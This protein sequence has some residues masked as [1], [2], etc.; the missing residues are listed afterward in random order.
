MKKTLLVT[1]VLSLLVI[2]TAFG[3]STRWN[4]MGGEHRFVIDTTNYSLYPGRITMFGNAAFIIPTPNF[5]DN[6]FVAGTLVNVKNM[7]LAYHYNLDTS[8]L[9]SLRGAL[10]GLKPAEG[11]LSDAQRDMSREDAGTDEWNKAKD[12]YTKLSQKDRLGSLVLREFPDL[13]WAMKTGKISLGARLALSMDSLSDSASPIEKAMSGG[14][15]T[16]PGEEASASAM[17]MDILLGATMYET[18][19]GDLD[20]GLGIGTQSYSDEDPNS[21]LTFESEGGLDI[22]F[23][24]RLSRFLDKDKNYTLI[25]VLSV[26]LGSNPTVAYNEKTAPNV[27]AVSYMKGDIGVGVRKKIKEKGLVVVGALG[28]YGATTA[29]PTIK[30]EEKTDL[31]TTDTS[32]ICTVLAGVEFPVNKWLIVRGGANVKFSSIVDEMLVKEITEDYAGE[33]KQTSKD[34]VGSKKFKNVDHY[35]NM[36][37]RTIYNGLIID[38]LLSRNILH[39]GPYILSGSEGNL[40]THI[41]VTYA[42]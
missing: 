12:V 41:C 25:P 9:R 3:A 23:N 15:I 18:P 35:F 20:L 1:V 33:G 19:A 6:D 5:L 36:G 38:F 4:A 7:T 11:A 2:S 32:M 21:G 16:G 34:V 39:R 37:V 24:G 14:K 13:F 31:G 27:N 26:N 42:F 28:A 17:A 22:S 10:A 8:G 40:A 30:G 29:T